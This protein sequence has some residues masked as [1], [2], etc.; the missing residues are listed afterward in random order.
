M[1]ETML[2]RAFTNYNAAKVL[3]VNMSCDEMFLNLVGYHLQQAVE[4]TIKF[5]LEINGVR[6]P[7]IHTIEQLIALGNE[8]DV[9]MHKCE[10]VEDHAEMFTAWESKSRY[11]MN[12]KLE[13]K[14]IERAVMEVEKFLQSVRSAEQS[15]ATQMKS[16]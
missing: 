3:L 14:K 10:Y 11:I 5:L 15:D 7:K 1:S 12:Y 2:D 6:Y 4:L 9:D 8:N 13:Q 16:F